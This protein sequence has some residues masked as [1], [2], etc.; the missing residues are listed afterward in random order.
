MATGSA[1]VELFG[2]LRLVRG[3]KHGYAGVRGGQGK[4]RDKFQAYTTVDSR[5]VTVCGLYESAHAAAVALA[6]WKQERELG[7]ADVEPSEK[8]PRK[9]RSSK[10]T[11]QPMTVAAGARSCHL[12]RELPREPLQ[13][14]SGPFRLP[15]YASQPKQPA[16]V[17]IA[18][19]RQRL[20]RYDLRC[21]LP[22]TVCL[23]LS[24]GPRASSICR[25]WDNR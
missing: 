18:S 4:Q 14:L 8:E 23:W 22:P 15:D 7:F 16:P 11:E 6:Q 21:L 2:S 12:V 3:G 1:D 13:L 19:L 9:R 20:C 5:K 10:S 17:P 25:Y 24:R